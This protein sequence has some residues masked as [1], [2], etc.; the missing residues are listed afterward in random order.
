[1]TDAVT[2]VDTKVMVA[3]GKV[4]HRRQRPAEHAFQYPFWMVW[5]D[6]D[7]IARFGEGSR[8]W[9]RARR[10][11]VLRQQDY[12]PGPAVTLKSRVIKK[13]AELGA[14][15]Q[16]GRVSMLGQPRMLGWLFNPLV[17]YW[18][19]P[20]GASVPDAVLAE[21]QNTPWKERHCYLLPLH[22]EGPWEVQ[23]PKQF[24]VS[25]F[26]DMAMDYHWQI[27]IHNNEIRVAIRNHDA[28][29]TIF[30]AGV[31]MQSLP[32]TPALMR[33]MALRHSLQAVKVSAAIHLHALRLWLKGVPF[34]VHPAKRKKLSEEK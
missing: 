14:D 13:A 12:L 30:Q 28:E 19:F 21:V 29:G 34:L 32:A 1:M 27:H 25:P 17:L 23:H 4:W 31:R 15:W 33:R 16:Q 18:H 7:E 9:G 20:E 11:V 10:P 8:L 5:V 24:H 3:S 2:D 6:L 26:L 22:G